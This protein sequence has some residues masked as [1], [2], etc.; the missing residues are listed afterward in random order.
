MEP[1]DYF[2]YKALLA[3]LETK[4]NSKNP[5]TGFISKVYKLS[6]ELSSNTDFRETTRYAFMLITRAIKY[7]NAARKCTIEIERRLEDTAKAMLRWGII[8][9]NNILETY[10]F[11]SH[12]LT[13]TP[14]HLQQLNCI[15]KMLQVLEGKYSYY[16][17][18]YYIKES[19]IL[20]FESTSIT[21]F[22]LLSSIGENS[23]ILEYL[24][25]SNKRHVLET[26]KLIPAL[27]EQ[28]ER[29]QLILKEAYEQHSRS[30]DAV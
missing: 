29:F 5:V 20:G 25:K 3:E 19:D 13:F 10:E 9:P 23:L 6:N 17:K 14:E 21:K 7:S 8:T 15:E 27:E 24:N 12:E 28:I 16:I 4:R 18:F 30:S 1:I 2:K 22:Y 11:W 26:N